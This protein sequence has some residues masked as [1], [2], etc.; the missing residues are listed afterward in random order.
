MAEVASVEF[1]AGGTANMNGMTAMEPWPTLAHR[2]GRVPKSVDYIVSPPDRER[3]PWSST[4][5]RA[6]YGRGIARLSNGFLELAIR[7]A[8][9]KPAEAALVNHLTKERYSW[10]V[11]EFAL[12]IDEHTLSPDSFAQVTCK[13]RQSQ[14][15]AS[16]EFTYRNEN[17]NV[18]VRYRLAR[19]QHYLRK[20]V[21][22]EARQPMVVKEARLLELTGKKV[23][24]PVLHEGGAYLPI[25]FARAPR[26]GVFACVEGNASSA[27]ASPEMLAFDQFPGQRLQSGDAMTLGPVVLG[28]Y[29]R[30]GRLYRNPYHEEGVELDRGERNWIIEYALDVS[31]I[32]SSGPI[33]ELAASEA[34]DE[35]ALAKCEAL[36]LNHIAGL[37]DP[38]A[39]AAAREKGIEVGAAISPR[40]SPTPDWSLVRASRDGSPVTFG[41]PCL[42]SAYVDWQIEQYDRAATTQGHR[43]ALLDDVVIAPCESASHAHLP[44]KYALFQAFSGYGRWLDSLSEHYQQTRG[45]GSHAC[46]G[47]AMAARLDGVVPLAEP[48]PL[49]LPDVRLMRMCADMNRLYLRRS[50]DFLM[51]AHRLRSS[52]GCPRSQRAESHFDRDAWRYSILSA[53]SVGMWLSVNYLPADLPEEDKEFA[54]Q[55]FS[56]QQQHAKYSLR[57]DPLLNEPGMEGIDGIAHILQDEGFVFLFNP[58]YDVQKAEL[59]LDLS[60]DHEY[61]VGETYPG[62]AML[63]PAE[64]LFFKRGEAIV[65]ELPPKTARV[66]EI[67]KGK[68]GPGLLRIAGVEV[69]GIRRM[70]NDVLAQVRGRPGTTIPARL[71]ERRKHRDFEVIFPGQPVQRGIASWRA[72]CNQLHAGLEAGWQSG[73]FPSWDLASAKGAFLQ[74]VWLAGQFT[75]AEELRGTFA[76]QAGEA[77]PYWPWDRRLIG[78]VRIEPPSAFDPIRTFGP[79]SGRPECEWGLGHKVGIGYSSEHKGEIRVWINGVA[80]QVHR[81]EGLPVAYVDVTDLVTYG[82][83]NTMVIYCGSLNSRHFKGVYF[84]NL[85]EVQATTTLTLPIQHR[86][87]RRAPAPKRE[88]K[89]ERKPARRPPAKRAAKRAVKPRKRPSRPA[90]RKAAAPKRAAARKTAKRPSRARR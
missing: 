28:V 54:R 21:E 43:D 86:A 63:L 51:P 71:M 42:G 74:S 46:Y 13:P 29:E 34:M 76:L 56:W 2:L 67:R 39:I 15:V 82:Q 5:A 73:A 58:T 87:A 52:I 69:D 44:G 23:L 62:R 38:G 53:V 36:G 83:P 85:P 10:E 3:R 70:A 75:L 1:P 40:Q 24:D 64:G 26:G 11:R 41:E 77:S 84:E 59:V 55:W 78:V 37:A 12:L 90:A 25:V 50:L 32:R 45:Y 8:A 81:E 18:R 33:L 72:A 65:V 47:L 88:R 35:D 9:G 16:I 80:V 14:Q 19:G 61:W 17:L 89:P 57:A 68:A 66:L 31:P 4:A 27:S 48:Y 6:Q 60:G 49:G 22:V 7:L 79:L 30:T 20:Q